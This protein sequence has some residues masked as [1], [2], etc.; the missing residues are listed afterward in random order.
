MAESSSNIYLHHTILRT[1]NSTNLQITDL[2]IT[3]LQIYELKPMT[4]YHVGDS[5]ER[6]TVTVHTIGRGFCG[7]VCAAEKKA[8]HTKERMAVPTD[9]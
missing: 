3:D 5:R 6:N 9:L 7:I 4:S 8:P 1:S 2:Q